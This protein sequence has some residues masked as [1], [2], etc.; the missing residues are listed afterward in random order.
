MADQLEPLTQDIANII[1]AQWQVGTVVDD[2]DL[3]IFMG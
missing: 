2:Y 3:P 1:G